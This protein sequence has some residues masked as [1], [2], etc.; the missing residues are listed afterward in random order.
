VLLF[1]S[2]VKEKSCPKVK[3]TMPS[4]FWVTKDVADMSLVRIK[5]SHC[6]TKEEVTLTFDEQRAGDSL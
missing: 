3:K 4:Y 5:E 6:R 2:P 1:L